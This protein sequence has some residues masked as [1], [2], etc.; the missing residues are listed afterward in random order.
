MMPYQVS[1]VY[2]LGHFKMPTYQTAN[3]Q[4]YAQSQLAALFPNT[5]WDWIQPLTAEF[6][7]FLG[8][9]I[10]PDVETDTTLADIK[11]GLLASLDGQRRVEQNKGLAYTFPDGV[12]G[13]VQTRDPTMWPDIINIVGKVTA[14]LI[15]KSQSI[16][17]SVIDFRDANNTM[18][19]MTPDQMIALGLLVDKFLSNLYSAKWAIQQQIQAL[20][21]V[22]SALVFDITQGWSM[23]STPMPTL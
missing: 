3:G 12:E 10:I 21:D 14:S 13:I 19:S 16:T 4:I 18:H 23:P 15:F 20:P 2:S 6:A 5:S 8:L 7:S 9:T 1:T 11:K 22:A 17:N